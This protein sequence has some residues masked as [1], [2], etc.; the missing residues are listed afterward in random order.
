MQIL[1]S[2]IIAILCSSF[3]YLDYFNISYK[4]LDTIFALLGFYFL[5]TINKKE[6]FFTGFFISI[7]WFWWIGYSFVYYELSYLI[8]LVLIG[9]GTVY[10][11]LF[12]I[13][14]VFNS[15]YIRSLYFFVLTFI[16][17][18]GFNWLQ[19]ELPF[20]NSY[21]GTS[22]IDFILV[23]VSI[24]IL[25]KLKDYKKYFTIIPLLFTL[26]YQN[27][28]IKMPNINIALPDINIP[29]EKKWDKRYL[30][31]IIDINLNEIDKAIYNKKDLIILP[32]TAFP[33][34]LNKNNSLLSYLKESVLF[35][36]LLCLI[37][38]SFG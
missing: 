25:I 26:N 14:G 23:I 20:I 3:I 28:T 31:N 16:Y 30:A 11:I 38:E 9:I 1:K 18:F 21:I 17:P 27:T 36:K 2:L 29:Q 33:L 12:Y 10:G 24:I 19:L 34:I 5:L 22:K 37:Y 13:A 35:D 4:L 6:L 8:P 32:E 7:L 15:L